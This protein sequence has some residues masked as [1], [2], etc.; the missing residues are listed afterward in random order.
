MSVSL[1]GSGSRRRSALLLLPALLGCTFSLTAAEQWHSRASIYVFLP[2]VDVTTRFPVDGGD[3]GPSVSGEAVLN[4]LNAA[5]M[6]T[7]SVQRG[8][9]GLFSDFIYLEFEEGQDLSRGLSLDDQPLPANATADIDYQLD[10]MAWSLLGEYQLGDG[11]DRV[12]LLA[13]GR[14]L[15]L[16]QRI[17]LQLSADVG[18][19]SGNGSVD[20]VLSE[21]LWDLV[22]GMRGQFSFGGQRQWFVPYYLDMGTGESE[23]TWQLAT[24]IGYGIGSA[25]ISLLYRHLAYDFQPG[26]GM[27]DLHFSGPMLGA[28]FSF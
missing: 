16:E 28:A 19:L 6:G 11:H 3:G 25:D 8:R 26:G 22:V 10:G 12:G 5:F 2:E 24:G 4:S 9:W 15:D 27:Q 18:N 21:Q 7:L 14:M 13:G 20:S 23:L 1:Y 17:N